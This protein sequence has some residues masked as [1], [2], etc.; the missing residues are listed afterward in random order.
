MTVCVREKHECVLCLEKKIEVALRC[1][2]FS[3]KCD[4]MCASVRGRKV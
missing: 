3:G 2:V 1:E 4:N